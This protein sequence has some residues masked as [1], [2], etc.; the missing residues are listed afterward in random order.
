MKRVIL[1]LAA[2]LSLAAVLPSTG[3]A[4]EQTVSFKS[5]GET[6]SGVL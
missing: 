6:G 5:G 1:A 4:A 3:A 2:A